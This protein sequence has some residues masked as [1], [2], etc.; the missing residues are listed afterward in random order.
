MRTREVFHEAPEDPVNENSQGSRPNEPKDEEKKASSTEKP[1]SYGSL[2]P[3]CQPDNVTQKSD[4]RDMDI[5]T[6]GIATK[7]RNGPLVSH[8]RHVIYPT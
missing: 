7:Y 5:G 6:Y 2:R 1:P 8:L 3:H 4:S